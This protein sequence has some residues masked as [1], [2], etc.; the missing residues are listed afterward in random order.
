[1]TFCRT[2]GNLF[3]EDVSRIIK[4]CR[5][6]VCSFVCSQL[7]LPVECAEACWC[8]RCCQLDLFPRLKP[9]ESPTGYEDCAAPQRLEYAF[10]WPASWVAALSISDGVLCSA[11]SRVNAASHLLIAGDCE[12]VGMVSSVLGTVRISANGESSHSVRRFGVPGYR[13]SVTV[14]MLSQ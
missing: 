5:R 11:C 4:L 1:M 8:P 7:V 14:V 2:P 12:A 9:R 13:Y 6:L 3:P 10:A